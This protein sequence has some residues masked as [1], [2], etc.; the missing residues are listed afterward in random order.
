MERTQQKPHHTDVFREFAQR[1]SE[2][3]GSSTAFACALFA[4][5]LWGTTG[6]LFGFSDTWQLVINTSTTIVT[7]LMVFLVQATQ[8]R[9]NKALQLKLDELL[10]AMGEARSSL[11]DLE[12]MPERDLKK[13]ESQ[14]R[15]LA[16]AAAASARPRQAR[17]PTEP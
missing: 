10:R 17:I 2:G 9:D 16:E 13:L 3:A 8:N 14:F 1:A 11:I 5:L 7:F 15:S 4:V 12:R 6:P